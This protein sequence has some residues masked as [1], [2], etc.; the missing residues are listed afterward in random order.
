MALGTVVEA[1]G[2]HGHFVYSDI[3]VPAVMIAG[4]I[5]ITPFRSMLGDLAAMQSRAPTTLLYSN[6]TP[7]IPFRA[8]FD[9]LGRDLPA[10]RVVHTVTRPTIEWQGP[11]GR[12]DADFI[13]QQVPEPARQVYF[14]CGPTALVE[15]ML[16]TLA[17]IGIDDSRIKH[18]GF[19]GYEA[20]DA[21]VA[22]GRR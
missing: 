12:I 1:S 17:E 19:P 11:T 13:Q 2:P 7:E 4:G 22:I 16:T 9:N 10:L 21:P 5:G 20:A 14:S 15:S 8:Y 6:A 3:G 18:A